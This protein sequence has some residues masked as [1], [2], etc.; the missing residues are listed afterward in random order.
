[1]Q[2]RASASNLL[3]LLR[4]GFLEQ[5][6]EGEGMNRP[7][8]SIADWRQALE[9][10]PRK[11]HTHQRWTWQRIFQVLRERS[12]MVLMLCAPLYLLAI[13]ALAAAVWSGLGR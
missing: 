11:V 10:G 12:C 5:G 8:W 2:H 7:G 9:D 6:T 1:M 3:E 13:L 4:P